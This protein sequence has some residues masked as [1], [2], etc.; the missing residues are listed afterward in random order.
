MSSIFASLYAG[1]AFLSAFLL[2]LLEP[3]FA[4]LMLPL[5]GGAANVWIAAMMFY[6]VTLLVGYGYAHLSSLLPLR[7]Q[8]LL[9]MAL[10]AFAMSVLPVAVPI[11]WAPP[12]EG[13]P[14]LALAGMMA[15]AIGAPFAVLSATAPLVQRWFSAA[16]PIDDPYFLYAISN[17]GSFTALL[18]YPLLVEPSLTLEAQTLIWSSGFVLLG[19]A[20]TAA[21]WWAARKA[22]SLAGGAGARDGGVLAQPSWPICAR[23][24]VLAAIPSS[25]MLS[26]TSFVATDLASIPLLWIVPL[27]LYLATFIVAFSRKSQAAGRAA[28]RIYP[29]LLIPLCISLVLV[30][31]KSNA[32]QAGFLPLHLLTFLFAALVCHCE[33]SRLKPDASQLTF[34]FFIVALGGALGGVFNSVVAP[35]VFSDIY[36]YP[37]GLALTC[38]MLPASV[39]RLTLAPLGAALAAGCAVALA[40][41]IPESADPSDLHYILEYKALLIIG[42]VLLVSVRSFPV[43]L[44]GGVALYLS[45]AIIVP[46]SKNVIYAERNFYGVNRV[47]NSPQTGLRM[48]EHGTTIHGLMALDEAHRLTPLGYYDSAGGIAEAALS[49]GRANQ[50]PVLAVVGLGSGQ[51]VCIGDK[52]WRY[53][54]YE[55]DPGVVQIATSASLFPFLKECPSRHS[56]AVGD[57]RMMLRRAGDG[58]Y[59]GIILDAFTSD[60][61]PLHLLTRNALEEYFRKLKPN[62]L[63]VLHLSNRYFNLPPVIA[64]AAR[65]MGLFGAGRLHEGGHVPGTGLPVYGTLVVSLSRSPD[66]LAPL[67]DLGWK[68]LKP[69]EGLNAWTDDWSDLLSTL[70]LPGRAAAPAWEDGKPA[71]RSASTS[72]H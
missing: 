29:I 41:W 68:R 62:G 36:E 39:R 23:W 2:F 44:A 61:I 57:G 71:M 60:S 38:L 26:T 50:R 42:A 58:A 20:M 40:E 24:L 67:F 65:D 59:D 16:R 31:G 56:I 18:V 37:I 8:W 22:S 70:M 47:R 43:A 63:L 54:F 11:G 53:D 3:M 28:A 48:I 27:G 13:N 51:M 64:A 17:A 52:T 30:L 72:A 10:S 14:V 32:N 35:A 9:H 19:G 15:L 6:Q 46:S 34:F 7:R 4:K 66:A 21:G 12:T 25:L 49:I 1:T 33:L 45:S 5:F 55:I 69:V